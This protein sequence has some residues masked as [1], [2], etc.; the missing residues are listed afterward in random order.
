MAIA[1]SNLS[2]GH[3][4]NR[5]ATRATLTYSGSYASG[6]ESVTPA[7]LGLKYVEEVIV[8]QPNEAG[9]DVRWDRS[10]TAPKFV[11]YD[12]DNTSGVAAEFSGTC[13]SVVRILAIGY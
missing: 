3:V 7:A 12:E 2:F 8:T 1:V 13:T 9:I 4:G 5:V 11:V 6:G 10:N